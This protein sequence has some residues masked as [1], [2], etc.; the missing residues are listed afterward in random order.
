MYN[1]S[2]P[3]RTPCILVLN[4]F[5]LGGKNNYIIRFVGV[6]LI[7]DVSLGCN[8]VNRSVFIKY[9]HLGSFLTIVCHR[10]CC[11]LLWGDTT[12]VD[13]ATRR[14][15]TPGLGSTTTPTL[16][17]RRWPSGRPAGA[18]NGRRPA[19]SRPP[20]GT[21]TGERPERGRASGRQGG[22]SAGR[23]ARRR[24][25]DL[26]SVPDVRRY[27]RPCTSIRRKHG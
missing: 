11:L 18:A 16:T 13:A 8:D 4:D 1:T 15:T 5:S 20:N 9:S 10:D 21:T 6:Y 14:S 2:S 17:R 27:H 22:R 7:F 26:C 23:S 19:S 24:P 3:Q 25:S 12:P